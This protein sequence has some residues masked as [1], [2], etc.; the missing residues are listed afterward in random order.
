M[1]KIF[2]IFVL[3]CGL[4]YVPVVEGRLRLPKCRIR[5]VDTALTIS[6]IVAASEG[7][8]LVA[9]LTSERKDPTT[10]IIAT[11][12]IVFGLWQL[13]LFRPSLLKFMEQH[14]VLKYFDWMGRMHTMLLSGFSHYSIRHLL[15]NLY[16][17]HEVG[18]K[19]FKEFGP[20][21]FAYFYIAALY[22]SDLFD[23]IIYVPML[24]RDSH[25]LGSLGASGAIS[26]LFAYYF[27]SLTKVQRNK[28][29]SSSE[30]KRQSEAWKVF[31]GAVAQEIFPEK[32]DH[33][34]HGA[35]LG[36]YIFGA[37]VYLLGQLTQK[38]TR[39]QLFDLM[40]TWRFTSIWSNKKLSRMRKRGI[41]KLKKCKQAARALATRVSQKTKRVLLE[42]VAKALLE[43][44]NIKAAM[45]EDT[46]VNQ[47]HR[48][49]PSV[50]TTTNDDGF[51]E[52]NE[53]EEE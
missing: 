51:E 34:A 24:R 11:N 50:D 10:T 25:A 28:K 17:L 40:K 1:K 37:N 48:S 23:M 35:H 6:P 16:A 13:S 9:S 26:A 33:I 20:R 15:S 52:G 38:H 47:S 36:G 2:L 3:S 32:D 5:L 39:E 29:N 19:I 8:A 46:E 43:I 27:L 44:D 45:E 4:C 14:F 21:R 41:V 22:A 31:I 18:P 12:A 53:S 30:K 49:A 7:T 42:Q